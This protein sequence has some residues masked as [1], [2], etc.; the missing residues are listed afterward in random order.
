M[1]RRALISRALGSWRGRCRD[2]KLTL[3]GSVTLVTGAIVVRAWLMLGYGPAFLGFGDSHE[4]VDA[5]ATG[6]F[7]DPQKP[8]GYHRGQRSELPW[9]PCHVSIMSPQ[10]W[11]D[12]ILFRWRDRN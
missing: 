2:E 6:V 1:H 3:A 12:R 11:F 4:Y 10:A 7:S 5:A 9:H 8:A